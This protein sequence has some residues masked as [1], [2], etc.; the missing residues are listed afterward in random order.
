WFELC[1]LSTRKKRHLRDSYHTTS[2]GELVSLMTEPLTG[3]ETTRRL[4]HRSTGLEQ[5][6]RR[7]MKTMNWS[8]ENGQEAKTE[9]LRSNDYR[10]PRVLPLGTAVELLQGS[11]SGGFTDSGQPPFRR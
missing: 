10:A 1:S 9:R 7:T 4:A 6:E 8:A 5:K 3:A 2:T 11:W